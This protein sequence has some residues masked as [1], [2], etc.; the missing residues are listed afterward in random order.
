MKIYWKCFSRKVIIVVSCWS[1]FCQFFYASCYHNSWIVHSNSVRKQKITI[2]NSYTVLLYTLLA[3][4]NI[5][6]LAV[7]TFFHSLPDFYCPVLPL[8]QETIELLFESFLSITFN[9]P[10]MVWQLYINSSNATCFEIQS[11]KQTKMYHLKLQVN[12]TLN[13]DNVTLLAA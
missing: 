3:L 13:A 11:V 9:I 1:Y 7:L 12:I 8:Y 5:L 10:W 6:C 2:W 4:A